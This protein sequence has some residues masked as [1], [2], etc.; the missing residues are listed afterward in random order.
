MAALRAEHPHFGD[1]TLNPKPPRLRWPIVEAVLAAYVTISLLQSA[2]VVF[3]FVLAPLA[4]IALE[5][6]YAIADK[7]QGVEPR[8]RQRTGSSSAASLTELEGS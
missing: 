7:L 3:L 4:L 8:S 2:S 6:A 1:F 5:L